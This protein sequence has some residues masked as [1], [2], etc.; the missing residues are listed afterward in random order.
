[1][2]ENGGLRVLKAMMTRPRDQHVAC[3]CRITITMC[4]QYTPDAAGVERI[5]VYE[6]LS[7]GNL[8]WCEPCL[9]V[10]HATGCGNCG[11]NPDQLCDG[12]QQAPAA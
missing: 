9:A 12:C 11:C 3:A 1:M 4:G 8:Q 5:T 7:V 2:G 10:W 6:G